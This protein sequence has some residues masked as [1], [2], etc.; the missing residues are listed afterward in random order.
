MDTYLT[1]HGNLTADPT[2]RTTASGATVV[3]IRVA[4]SGRRFDKASGEF[5]DGDPMFIAASCWRGLGGHV[6][7]SLR[8]GDSVIVYGRL[9][10]R[11]YDD[12]QGN[13]RSV[14]EIDAI[15]V[16]PDLARCAAD[17]R[18]PARANDTGVGGGAVGDGAVADAVRD[19]QPTSAVVTEP[20]SPVAA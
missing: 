10:S 11:T 6:L 1:V 16:G 13:R 9:L 15:A 14:H 3:G 4:S 2:H 19:A 8:K 12:K 17:L 7:A 18:R 20:A 5:R